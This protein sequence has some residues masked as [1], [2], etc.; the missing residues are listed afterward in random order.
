MRK[1]VVL[2]VQED[3]AVR[4]TLRGVAAAQG[5]EVLEAPYR[6]AAGLARAQ[7]VGLVIVGSRPGG[8]WDELDLIRELRAWS[9][10]LPIILL[11]Q[12]SSE[13]LAIAALRERVDDYLKLPVSRVDLAASFRRCLPDAAPGRL[14]AATPADSDGEGWMVSGSPAMRQIRAYIDKVAATDTNV[15]VTGETGTGKELVARLI[16]RHSARRGQPFVSI[17]C[18]AIPETLVESELFGYERGAFTGATMQKEGKLKL[19]D[20]GTV[21]LD[22]IGDMGLYAQAKILRALESREVQRLGGRDSVGLDVRIVAATNQDLE[23]LIRQGR[24]RKDLYF[25]LNVA[26]IHLPPLRER[27]DDIPVLVDRYVGE[28]NHRF[29][30]EVEG[31]ADEVLEHF[32]RYEWPGN[33]RELRN[34]LEASFIS[35]S[36]PR[37]SVDDLPEPFRAQVAPGPSRR[38]ER[39]RLL[40]ALSSTNWNKSKAALMLR[41][42][43]MT[44]YRKMAKYRLSMRAPASPEEPATTG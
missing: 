30:K 20:R 13:A 43:R 6:L 11:T 25:R 2:V 21:Y 1:P 31:L 8:T 5:C 36:S 23:G 19:A 33:V 10:R 15:L 29:G 3:E 37:I 14:R 34:I 17:N 22:E 16:H 32:L 41:W 40:D 26:C 7:R 39:A 42:S 38:D 12:N 4:L 28:L 27:K 18:A 35:V 44:V 24:F 9:P